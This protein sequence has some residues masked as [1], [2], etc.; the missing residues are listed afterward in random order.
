MEEE[1]MGKIS[2]AGFMSTRA[3]SMSKR[4]VEAETVPSV[5]D[6]E[7]SEVEEVCRNGEVVKW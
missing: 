1:E 5:V 3:M 4:V 6:V 2:K 7:G